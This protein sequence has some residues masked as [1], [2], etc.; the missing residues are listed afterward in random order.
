MFA[1]YKDIYLKEVDLEIREGDVQEN[2]YNNAKDRAFKMGPALPPKMNLGMLDMQANYMTQMMQAYVEQVKTEPKKYI[3]DRSACSRFLNISSNLALEGI[4]LLY[5]DSWMNFTQLFYQGMDWDLLMFQTLII[6][7]ADVG[8]MQRQDGN[9]GSTA[10]FGVLLAFLADK[11]F[12]IVRKYFGRRN[13][14][15]KTLTDERFLI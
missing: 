3:R 14:A 15:K 2:A 4:P 5:R 8:V 9:I 1:D 11:F 7:A 10:V 12:Y 6:T 13:I